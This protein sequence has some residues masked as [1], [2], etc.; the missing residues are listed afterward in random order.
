MSYQVKSYKDFKKILKVKQEQEQ[1]FRELDNSVNSLRRRRDEYAEK[2]KNALKSGDQS[3]YRSSVALLK[4]AMFNLAQMEEM[5]TNFTY[6]R[7]ML[8][9]QQ[10]NKKF[11]KTFT[12]VMDN[13]Y[14]TC[15]SVRVGN[16][17]KLFS[18]AVFKGNS[19]SMELREMLRE[20]NMTFECGVNSIS[21]IHDDDI[22]ELL[23]AEL[24]KENVDFD[25]SLEDLEKEFL[26]PTQEPVDL[27]PTKKD[28]KEEK[29]AKK[30][31]KTKVEK[32]PAIVDGGASTPAPVAPATPV[33]PV[34]PVAPATPVAPVEPVTP[35]TPV[36]PVE[37][38]APATPVAPVE[39]VA[40]ATPVAPVE[41]T[42]TAP[43]PEKKE[44]ESPE[45]VVL[46]GGAKME[47]QFNWDNLPEVGF[48]DIAGLEEVKEAVRVK[49]LL[50]LKNPEV[51]EGYERKSGGGLCLYGPPGTGK[52]MIAAAIAREIG[53]KFCSVKPSDLLQTGIGNTEKAI[54]A[55]FAEARSFPCAVIYF[56]EMDSIA[57]KDT[58]AQ[59][60]KQL[61]SE[62][63][64]QLQGV[65]S[66]SKDKG[67]ILFLVSATNK[68]WAIDSAFLRPGRFG[69][70][71]YVGLPDAPARRYIIE[72]RFEK[73][74]K[75]GKVT[76]SSEIDITKAVEA[77]NGFNCS[78]ISNLLDKIVENSA[79]RSLETGEKI[80]MPA[81]VEKALEEIH[82]TVQA[83]DIVK[84][85]EWKGEND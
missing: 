25:C 15:K 74:Q 58:K 21:D 43:V 8:E 46:N 60:A 7:D 44:E 83:D 65:D 29:K 30:D 70:R 67:N 26:K 24:K 32:V 75:A 17:S 63:L 48:D 41:P 38:V 6:A 16:V 77:T 49:V 55:L 42:P 4:N 82:S 76:V 9:M 84:L 69:T 11:V 50:P 54:K 2:A 22:K 45:D 73:I 35:A 81:D 33:A 72:K 40:P 52:T 51:F 19:T 28:K 56:D 61:R 39:P 12:S 53:A 31:E 62:F 18:K 47:Y 36:A 71:V 13:V 20:N 57:P 10:M 66:Y 59:H 37:P 5:R 68:P 79:I 23:Q 3:Q 80:I 34:A 85:K 14:K 1:T 78:D 64:A 27:A